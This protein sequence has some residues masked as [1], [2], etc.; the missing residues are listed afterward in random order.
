M[1]N[2]EINAVLNYEELQRKANEFAQQ[3]AIEVIK[4]YYTGYNSP[5]KAAIKEEL[6]KKGVSIHMELPDIMALLNEGIAEE[7]N[8]IANEAIAKTYIP[9]V[10]NILTRIDGEI[11]LSDILKK[12]IE[13]KYINYDDSYYVNVSKDSTHDW[14]NVDI[15]YDK[16][17]YS[18]CLHSD[19]NN[20]GKYRLLSL[21]YAYNSS[22]HKVKVTHEKTS[23]EIPF[24]PNVLQDEFISYLAKLVM[25]KTTI[26]VDCEGFEDDWFENNE[27]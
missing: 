6:E 2:K 9:L 19:H 22:Y 4:D 24:H 5:F 25:S 13:V 27:Y 20:K 10:R 8:T 15:E 23:L 17:K 26:T 11:R 1:S 16:E 21:P 12:F 18:L 3:G 14:Y 7:I